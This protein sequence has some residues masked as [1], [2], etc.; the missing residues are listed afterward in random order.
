MHPTVDK[1]SGRARTMLLGTT[2]LAGLGMAAAAVA[3]AFAQD[4]GGAMETVVVTGYRASLTD[5]T[6]AKRASVGFT[7]T[8]FAE[9]IGKFPDTNIAESFNRI[10]GVTISRD[11]DGEGV[12]IQIRGLGPSFTKVLLNGAQVAMG[13]TGTTDAQGTNREVDLNMLPS[14]LFTQLTVNKTP[15]A[16]LLE[17]GAAGTV[18]MRTM[19]PFDNPGMHITYSAQGTQSS[20]DHT[21]VGEHGTLIV[22]DTEGPFGVLI[23]VTGL[24]NPVYT[25][26]FETIG[27]TTPKLNAAM[28]PAN[29][30]APIGGGNWT[31]PATVPVNVTTGG[32]VPGATIDK[33]ML[34]ALNPGLTV[35][36]LGTAL[37]PRLGRPMFEQGTRS[38]FNGVVSLEYRPTDNLHFYVDMIGGRLDN[39]LNRSD[40]DWVGRNGSMIPENLKLDANGVVTSGTFANSQFFLEARPYKE[41]EDFLSINPGMEWQVTD[42]FNVSLKA[43]V[44][45]SHFFRDSPTILVNTPASNA[46][47]P[48]IP[49]TPLPPTG[50][51]F[52]T[53]TNNGVPTEAFNIDLNNPANFVWA[54]GRVNIQDEKRYVYT[55]GVHLDMEYGGD[56][57]NVKFG[58]AFDEAYRNIMGYD[59]SQAWQNAVCGD[60]PNVYLPGPNSEPG[61][62]GLVLTGTQ[63]PGTSIGGGLPAYPGYGTYYSVGM[64]TLTWAGS[65]IPQ[66]NLANYLLPGPAGFITAN[67][68]KIE[69]DAHFAAFDYPNAPNA[70]GANTGASAGL[71]D[72]KNWGMYAEANGILHLG[73]R[74]LK[75]NVG[76]RWVETHQRIGGY[77]SHADP[78]DAAPYTVPADGGKYPNYNTWTLTQHT[79]QSFLPSINLA[80]EVA[81]DFEVRGSISRT[82]TRPNPSSMLPGVNFGD[83]SAAQATVGNPDLAPF[84]SNNIDLGAELYTGG[85]GYIGASVFRKGI[86]GFTILGNTTEPFS[87]LAQYGITYSTANPT[88]QA[89]LQARGCT[90][91]TNC[92]TTVII[93]KQ[94]NA[95]GLETI[96]GVEMDMVQPLDFLTDPY[97]GFTGLGVTAN[98]TIV[99]QKS[100]GAAPAIATGVAP[101]TYNLT[102]YYE[103]GGAM[104]RMSYNFTARE[105]NSGSNQNGICLPTATS[106]GCPGGAYL[107]QQPYGQ[108]DFSSS[109]KLSTLFG[110]IPSDPELTFDIQNVFKAK[111][112]ATFQYPSAPFTY[113]NQGSLY[114]IGIRGTF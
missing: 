3:P 21:A 79:Y 17:G 54:G 72:E 101:Y 22:S 107:F 66:A 47:A 39:N 15:Y 44:T 57:M 64:P 111:L 34:L 50:G 42:L 25:T 62:N 19:R 13:S 26:G 16:D 92:N 81:D 58:G 99:D 61:C 5:S 49:G 65:Y 96:N 10:P 52:V 103:N 41:K 104:L 75:Y 70:T 69:R 91:D 78:R 32:L 29:D 68:A 89:A 20:N 76:L 38:R 14:E 7:D 40:I 18:N 106:A 108:A 87:F 30:C 105:Y 86:S 63:T 59:N 12:N 37:I 8:V 112:K 56:E 98:F 113:Y 45:R 23:G 43:N 33:A 1:L 114:L 24:V 77:V 85:E 55:N 80:Y 6:N 71:V 53:Y 36:Q 82:M 4:A 51:A 88:Q 100:S 90:S 9:D 84:Y 46:T 94:V 11:I 74:S 73:D 60:N 97:L 93:Q 95:N 48:T 28:C 27:W 110:T 109:L 83:P 31:I 2:V 35:E 102:G 67:Y